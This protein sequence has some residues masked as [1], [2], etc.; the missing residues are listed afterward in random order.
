[1][2]DGMDIALCKL[3]RKKN[4]LTFAGAHNSLY[5]V[6]EH[7]QKFEENNVKIKGDKKSLIEFKGDKQPIGKYTFDKPFLQKEIELNSG[8]VDLPVHRWISGSVWWRQK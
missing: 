8:D 6:T 2:K 4:T 5:L 3:N 7:A 1:M